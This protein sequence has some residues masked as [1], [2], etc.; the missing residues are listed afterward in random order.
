MKICILNYGTGN[1]QS[2]QFAL[3][4]LGF[5]GYLSNNYD[6]ICTADKIILPGVG[7]A[8]FAMKKLQETGLD[9]IDATEKFLKRN[10]STARIN[11]DKELIQFFRKKIKNKTNGQLPKQVFRFNNYLLKELLEHK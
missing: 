6:E 9:K 2:I 11:E 8:S 1:I 5:E 4:R 10:F 7:E 3:Q